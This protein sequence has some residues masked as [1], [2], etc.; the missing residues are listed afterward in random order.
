MSLQIS[1][2]QIIQF[3][4]KI[5]I[6]SSHRSGCRKN[7]YLVCR[8]YVNFS[9]LEEYEHRRNEAVPVE[10]GVGFPGNLRMSDPLRYNSKH[11][12]TFLHTLYMLNLYISTICLYI[13]I[14]Y[15]DI[16]SQFSINCVPYR[17]RR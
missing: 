13:S 6:V 14:N 17:I 12:E 11:S 8:V 4:V 1:S 9:I 10:F 2:I 3:E 15:F 5:A 16:H 7:K